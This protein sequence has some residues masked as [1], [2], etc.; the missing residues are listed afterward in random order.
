[1]AVWYAQSSTADVNSASLW[2]SVAAG[3]GST[4]TWASLGATDVLCANGKT[5]LNCNVDFTCG[6]IQTSGSANG[7]SGTD[8][9]GFIVDTASGA[10][11]ITAN[12]LAGTT[13]C[14]TFQTSATNRLVI[15]GNVTGGGSASAYGIS[16]PS[17]ATKVDVTGDVT[18]GSN[19]TAYGMFCNGTAG[20]ATVTGTVT[21]SSST[22]AISYT[23]ATN[24]TITINGTL[25]SGSTRAA[26]TLSTVAVIVI[27]NG[28]MHSTADWVFPV[29]G[30]VFKLKWTS[31][32]GTVIKLYN[33]AASAIDLKVPDYPALA[34]VKSGVQ[35]DY[36]TKT[37]TLVST[38]GG[39]PV[40][41]G[42]VARRA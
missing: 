40:F 26:L 41:G 24:D 16:V 42:S 17:V 8:G 31:A 7:A 1:M 15:N 37:G 5:A 11:T 23:T 28:A 18:G 2:N 38:G 9:G 6:T 14:L 25:V 34:D 22:Y 36:T 27:M 32:A 39:V 29:A 19:A 10:R 13:A 3:G 20:A 4:L 21:G 12:I 30:T 35:Y 33:A